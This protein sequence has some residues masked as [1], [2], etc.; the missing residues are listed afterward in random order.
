[1]WQWECTACG[2]VSH[3]NNAKEAEANFIEH[4]REKHNPKSILSMNT[5]PEANTKEHDADGS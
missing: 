4:A 2:H 3:G 1:M 5:T